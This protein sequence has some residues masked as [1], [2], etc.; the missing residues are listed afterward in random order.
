MTSGPFAGAVMMTFFAPAARC[1]AASSRLVKMPVDSKTTSTP[2]AF[3]G[4]SAGSFT[5]STLNASPSTVMRAVAGRDVGLEVAEHRVVLQQV[6]ERVGVG[7]IVD[8][9]EVDVVVA[10]RGPHDV[11]SDSPETVDADLDGHRRSFCACG[12]MP[13]PVQHVIV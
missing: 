1:F 7:E 3:H 13:A 2:S 4:S 6:R 9:D 8:R 12:A 5:D 10:E 11:A